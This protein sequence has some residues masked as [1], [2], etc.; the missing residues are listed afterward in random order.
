M[1]GLPPISDIHLLDSWK[2]GKQRL[3]DRQPQTCWYTGLAQAYYILHTYV[4]AT[5]RRAEDSSMYLL[6]YP[7]SIGSSSDALSSNHYYHC[8]TT[9]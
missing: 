1:D 4:F 9:H 7:E 2:L 8:Q 5:V 6:V 3:T